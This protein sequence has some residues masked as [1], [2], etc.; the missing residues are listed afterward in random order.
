MK[1]FLTLS[2]C[3]TICFTIS[4][5]KKW[6]YKIKIFEHSGKRHRGFFYAAEDTRLIIVKS[7]GDTS[8]L[9][10][11]KIS[12]LYIHRRGIVAPLA[13][14]GA[15]VFFVLAVE[16]PDALESAVLI[17]VGIPVGVS[18]GL[19]TGELFANK[20]FYKKLETKDF[21]LI[22]SDLQRYTELK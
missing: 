3:L 13:I 16:S 6:K 5:Q 18:L 21:P 11:E 19:F 8:R 17:F 9:S 20:R 22:K 10:A 7:N 15:L 14:A 12:R 1:I 4:A 2:L